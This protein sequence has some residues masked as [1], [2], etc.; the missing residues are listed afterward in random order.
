MP[1][2]RKSNPKLLR[3]SRSHASVANG[4]SD[5][6]RLGAVRSFGELVIVGNR[7]IYGIFR[8]EYEAVQFGDRTQQAE[9]IYLRCRTCD[10]PEAPRG[11]AV[12]VRGDLY[13]VENPETDSTGY[14]TLRLVKAH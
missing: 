11:T 10:L 9:R 13:K 4:L 14:T 2:R 8:R 5:Q 7:T 6:D 1:K 12:R 3:R